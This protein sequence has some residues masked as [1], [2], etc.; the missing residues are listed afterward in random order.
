MGVSLLLLLLPAAEGKPAPKVPVGKATTYV[1]GPLDTEGYIDYE[2]ALNER[3]SKGVT[4]EKNA[5]V[6]LWKAFGPHPEKAKMPP[7]FFHWLGIDEP[8]EVGDYFI[9]LADYLRD[10]LKYDRA[11]WQT[12]FDQQSHAGQR[13][14]SA[15]DYPAIASWLQANEKPLAMVVAATRRPDYFNPLVTRR[16]GKRPGLLIGALLPAVQKCRE[17]ATALTARAMLHAA[18]QDFEAAW[19]DLLACHRLARLMARGGTLIEGLVGLALEAVTTN[20]DLAFLDRAR[21]TPKQLRDCLRDLQKLPPMPAMADGI[22]LTERLVFLDALQSIR[23]GGPQVME[24]LAGGALP[25]DSDPKELEALEKIDWAPAFRTANEW[26]DRLV[27]ALRVKD[28]PRRQKELS[29]IEENLK[30]LTKETTEGRDRAKLFAWLLTADKDTGKLIG[31]VAVCLMM[32]AVAK[33]QTAH[34][35]LEQVQRNLHLAF[36]LAAY[37]SEHRRYPAK[38]D[39][40][41]PK[42]LAA[43]PDDLFSGKAMI[44]RPSEDGYLLYSI[45]VNGKDDGGRWSDDDPPGDDLRVRMPLPELKP[46]K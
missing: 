45:G 2:T 32:P 27:A 28:R 3:L 39:E 25:K 37:R 22:D 26:Y 18:E 30:A 42:Y 9:P 15:K 40:L 20:A 35:R 5:N 31:N 38:L 46:K 17:L 13:A 12:V 34:E 44:Y 23:R 16:T 10:H 41:T 19:Q 7:E 1:T 21:L 4:P 11:E 43:I 8:P 24:A 29:R 6:L 33:V 36:A 14:W